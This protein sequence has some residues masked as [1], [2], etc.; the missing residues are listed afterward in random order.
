MI[1]PEMLRILRNVDVLSALQDDEEFGVSLAASIEKAHERAVGYM[2]KRGM[3][4][5]DAVL[6]ALAYCIG[7]GHGFAWSDRITQYALTQHQ[8]KRAS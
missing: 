4:R 5:D 8:K 6:M 7:M 2:T 1:P 3:S